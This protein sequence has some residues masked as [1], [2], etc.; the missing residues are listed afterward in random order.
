M[1][2]FEW[3]GKIIVSALPQIHFRNTCAIGKDKSRNNPAKYE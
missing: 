3:L 1:A 2:K